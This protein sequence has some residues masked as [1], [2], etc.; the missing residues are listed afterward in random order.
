MVRIAKDHF[1]YVLKIKLLFIWCNFKR[2][3]MSSGL[4]VLW[5]RHQGNYTVQ[6][7]AC[8]HTWDTG[9]FWLKMTSSRRSSC[10]DIH[11]VTGGPRAC[12]IH[13]EALLDHEHVCTLPT[14]LPLSLPIVWHISTHNVSK[15]SFASFNENRH[16]SPCSITCNM[17]KVSSVY[18]ISTN[19]CVAMWML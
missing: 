11:P 2:I 6:E 13:D 18:V 8:C 17:Y 3:D 5:N 16:T 9:H 12:G 15:V 10:S 4:Q 1:N 7:Q 19:T 14:L